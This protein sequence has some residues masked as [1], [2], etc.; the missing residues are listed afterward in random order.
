MAAI[1]NVGKAIEELLKQS[2]QLSGE[3]EKFKL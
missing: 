1:G 3:V 2:T